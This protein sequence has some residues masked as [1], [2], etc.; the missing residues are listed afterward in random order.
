MRNNIRIH[1]SAA[2]KALGTYG[3][4]S[5]TISGRDGYLSISKKIIEIL[6]IKT[7]LVLFH[8]PTPLYMK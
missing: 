1:H 6:K 4:L 5:K 3:M 8:E 2:I 7:N